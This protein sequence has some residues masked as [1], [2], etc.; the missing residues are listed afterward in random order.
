MALYP[1]ILASAPRKAWS[2]F[3][4]LRLCFTRCDHGLREPRSSSLERRRGF[5]ELNASSSCPTIAWSMQ[6]TLSRRDKMEKSAAR[7]TALVDEL[8]KETGSRHS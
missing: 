7:R 4:P 2:I 6:D 3:L 8:P 1:T 5:S